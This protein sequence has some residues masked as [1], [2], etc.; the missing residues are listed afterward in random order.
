VTTDPNGGFNITGDYTCP[1]SN[2]VY[3]TAAGGDPGSG[4]NS[5]LTLM[6]A[7]GNCSTFKTNAATTFIQMNEVT[8]VAA[9]WALQQFASTTGT[10]LSAN[11]TT[12]SDNIGTTSGNLQG[13]TNAMNMANVLA[14]VSTG[15][16]PGNNSTSN[17]YNVEYWQ[18][19]TLANI[20][21]SCVNT[22]GP[23]VSPAA[24]NNCNTLFTA[25]NGA[26][27]TFQA[28][29][30]MAR[31]PT[32]SVST[33]L[34]LSSTTAPFQPSDA[35]M[36]DLTVGLSFNTGTTNSRWIAFDSYGNAWI[37]SG[38]AVVYEMDPTGNLISTPTQ[39]TI[40]SATSATNIVDSYEV[41]V[42]TANNA[43]FTDQGANAIFEV[44]GSSSAG[45]A[46]GGAGTATSTSTVSS[47]AN[48]LDAIAIDSSN[49]IWASVSSKNVVGLISGS[50]STLVT[51]G[52]LTGNPFMMAVD[53]SNRSDKTG[54]NNTAV[55][56][57]GSFLYTVDS[58]GCASKI[59]VGGSSTASGAG[60]VAMT[61][62]AGGSGVAGTG[63]P[64]GF[65]VDTACGSTTNVANN[66]TY[67]GTSDPYVMT[68]APYGIAFDNSNNMWLVNQNYTSQDT[69][70]GKYSLTKVVAQN[71]GSEPNSTS[72]VLS[73]ANDAA[74]FTFTPIPG[75]AGG[76]NVPFYLAMD[77]AG[78]AWV[79]NSVGAGL[80]AFSNSGTA[81][82][83]ATGFSGGKYTSATPVTYARSYSNSRGVAVDISGNVW[84]ANPGA[85][86]VTVVVGQA[87][88]TVT[89][90]SLGIKNGTLASPPQ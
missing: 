56:H 44:L 5:A 13:L 31:H 81:I 42:D 76:L 43:W 37:A 67:G 73:P 53:M 45:G 1:T 63:T 52:G 20:I 32:N 60:S 85:T 84:V 16:S 40:G 7:I 26:T 57:N 58:G 89:P 88:P 90:L 71:Y 12:P 41:A 11:A 49:D 35:S 62:T 77:G 19:N 86:Y 6:A 69:A 34:G 38:G 79:A 68:S 29:L 64:L 2:M 28:A 46:N 65:I 75:A 30:Y 78:A 66:T 83:P 27:D 17:A 39:Y 15:G 87:T 54:Y 24:G 22:T 55:S 33:L 82:S 70:S 3:L 10:A 36:N 18:I 80:S 8:T 9:I 74:N 61:Y 4:T 47:S 72:P 51:G 21:A 25:T 48:N 59:T 14:S 50:Y 23:T